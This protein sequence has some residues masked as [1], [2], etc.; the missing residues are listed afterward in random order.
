M[1]ESAD[2]LVPL[3]EHPDSW[4]RIHAQRLLVEAR[5][6]A[7]APALARM[8][9]GSQSPQGRVHAFWTLQ[10]LGLLSPAQI[11]TALKDPHPGVVEN[12][13]ALADPVRDRATLLQ[14]IRTRTDRAAFLALL[15]LVTETADDVT[16]AC[17]H[18]LTGTT[19]INDLWMRR[20]ILTG[21]FNRVGPLLSAILQGRAGVKEN[22]T[23]GYDAAVEEFATGLGALNDAKQIA[24]CSTQSMARATLSEPVVFSSRGR[25]E[26]GW[27]EV[28]ANKSRSRHSWRRLPW[29]S[30]PASPSSSPFLM[31][32][33]SWLPILHAPPRNASR[34]CRWPPSKGLKRCFLWWND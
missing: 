14:L 31:K 11:S 5:S 4:R 29:R 27:P 9:A 28:R 24:E 13:L 33:V 26:L 23:T 7:V 30:A 32:P 22:E 2:A 8:L 25:W 34:P 20:A 19:A 16:E 17:R 18:L 21:D 6:V 1:P 12:A 15:P 3:L 10:G